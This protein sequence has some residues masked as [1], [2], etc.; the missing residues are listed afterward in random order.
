MNL[1]CVFHTQIESS[2]RTLGTWSSSLKECSAFGNIHSVNYDSIR[3]I[4]VQGMLKLLQRKALKA[5]TR[6]TQICATEQQELEK[7]EKKWKC[8]LQAKQT[9]IEGR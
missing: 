5:E 2:F 3:D 4:E 1:R 7:Q 6:E 9:S 8:I